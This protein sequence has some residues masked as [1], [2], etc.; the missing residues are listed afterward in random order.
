MRVT[1][2]IRDKI[3]AFRGYSIK[4]VCW[5]SELKHPFNIHWIPRICKLYTW[6]TVVPNTS[7]GLILTNLR[8]WQRKSRHMVKW[9]GRC[10]Q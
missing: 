2:E 1:K 9:T 3:L 4:F 5:E 6:D 10:H 7:L 8:S